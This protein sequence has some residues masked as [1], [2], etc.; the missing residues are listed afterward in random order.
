MLKPRKLEEMVNVELPRL[1]AEYK[2]T[3]NTQ[4]FENLRNKSAQDQ[5]AQAQEMVQPTMPKA[6]AKELSNAKPTSAA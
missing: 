2:I 4:Y 5:A 1:E 6:P 3:E